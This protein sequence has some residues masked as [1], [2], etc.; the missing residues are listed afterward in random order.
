MNIEGIIC[1][2]DALKGGGCRTLNNKC[3]RRM[4]ALN[5]HCTCLTLNFFALYLVVHASRN[6]TVCYQPYDARL[7]LAAAA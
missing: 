1:M 2:Q 6:S 5:P 3:T 4:Y 7:Q